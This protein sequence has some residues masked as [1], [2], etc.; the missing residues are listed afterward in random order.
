MTDTPET[1]TTT[2]AGAG[3]SDEEMARRVAGETSPDLDAADVFEREAAGADTEDAVADADA[4]D[5]S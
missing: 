2:S 5:L 1:G 4:D 3:I